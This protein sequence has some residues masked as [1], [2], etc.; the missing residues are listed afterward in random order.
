MSNTVLTLTQRFGK[1]IR[2]LPQVKMWGDT[3]RVCSDKTN[4][5]LLRFSQAVFHLIASSDDQ[6][7][8]GLFH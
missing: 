4:S 8:Q 1:P 5:P 6:D 3:Y 2:F 7:K